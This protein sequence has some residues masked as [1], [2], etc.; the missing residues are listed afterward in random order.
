MKN[1]A[2]QTH[3]NPAYARS[4][5]VYCLTVI[6]EFI[7]FLIGVSLMSLGV[8]KS[9]FATPSSSYGISNC[10]YEVCEDN[11]LTNGSFENCRDGWIEGSTTGSNFDRNYNMHG[12]Y[13]FFIVPY[14]Y[15]NTY[16]SISQTHAATPGEVYS[17]TFYAGVHNT[18]HDQEVALQFLDAYGSVL[19]QA[20]VDIDHD[21][22]VNYQLEE[23]NL[24]G[25]A[26]LGTA[27]VK[28]LGSVQ[29]ASGYSYAYLKIDGVCLTKAEGS[30][31]SL[32]VE[33]LGFTAEEQE[34]NGVLTWETMSE[35]NASHFEV[36]FS[37]DGDNFQ[38]IGQV[39]AVGNSQELSS[40]TFQDRGVSSRFSGRVYYRLRQV[41]MDGKFSYSKL[42]SLELSQRRISRGSLN[43]YP[44][45]ASR[46]TR[47]SLSEELAVDQVRVLNTVG[48]VMKVKV[49]STKE[50]LSIHLGELR[51]GYYIT[52]ILTQS[53][54]KMTET[55][56][57]AN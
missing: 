44:N 13:N 33:W 27:A 54:Q 39:S 7:R 20:K 50:G 38:T 46:V 55:L 41:D 42:V 30:G 6:R 26:P 3:I 21:V 40:Y 49:A 24:S 28:V 45:P 16:A 57:V 29:K 25:T 9:L 48:E 5:N 15:S 1:L 23:Y 22:S 12:T 35:Y 43:L 36:E 37:K 4:L 8:G 18:L 34:E 32:P 56:I 11:L 31:S 47:I 2:A 14:P 52:Q 51:P 53:G 10:D 19:D 17:L